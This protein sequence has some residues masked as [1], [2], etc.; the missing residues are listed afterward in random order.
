MSKATVLYRWGG[1]ATDLVSEKERVRKTKFG[2]SSAV[3]S[4]GKLR[5]LIHMYTAALVRSPGELRC[6]H[7]TLTSIIFIFYFLII[8]GD[9]LSVAQVGP[10]LVTILRSSCPKREKM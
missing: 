4:L 7:P 6:Q 2:F 10:N 1:L 5:H 8:L 3:P 9:S